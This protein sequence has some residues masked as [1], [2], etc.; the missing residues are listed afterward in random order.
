MSS[1]DIFP[2]IRALSDE[3]TFEVF[4]MLMCG[5]G[6]CRCEIAD[7]FGISKDE[8]DALMKDVVKSGLVDL[9]EKDGKTLYCINGTGM[10]RLTKFFDESIEECRSSGTCACRCGCGDSCC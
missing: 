5:K 6:I 10:C 3:R 4:G 2:M 8:A 9:C 1:N 7:K